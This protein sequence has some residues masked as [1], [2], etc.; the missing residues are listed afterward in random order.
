MPSPAGELSGTAKT[1]T[2]Q[3]TVVGKAS[4]AD[5]SAMG[6]NVDTKGQDE[7]I[8]T[9][10]PMSHKA[11][12]PKLQHR[13]AQPQPPREPRGPSRS[14]RPKSLGSPVRAQGCAAAAVGT[15][16]E[17]DALPL[18]SSPRALGTAGI[19]PSLPG[20]TGSSSRDGEGRGCL[21]K[22]PDLPFGQPREAVVQTGL[23]RGRSHHVL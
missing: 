17:T 19:T 15:S 21:S 10:Q 2:I 4:L 13:W 20:A 5:P 1:H 8:R 18:L 14:P 16:L 9:L 22:G 12:N 7:L 23:Q 6:G 11:G 3:H